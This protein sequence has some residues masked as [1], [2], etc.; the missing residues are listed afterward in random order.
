LQLL[1]SQFLGK[2]VVF[3]LHHFL[4]FLSFSAGVVCSTGGGVIFTRA[5]NVRGHASC[6]AHQFSAPFFRPPSTRWPIFEVAA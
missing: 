3:R 1:L 6:F 5:N 2:I 4:P